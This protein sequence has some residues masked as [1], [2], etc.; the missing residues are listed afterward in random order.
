MA[1]ITDPTDLVLNTEIVVSTGAKT[2]Q[3]LVAGNLSNDGVNMQAVYSKLKELW[4]SESTL[5]PHPFPMV[6]IDADAGKYEIGTDGSNFNGWKWADTTTR[7][8]IRSA[9]W[10][11]ISDLGAL[12]AEHAGIRSL[13]GFEDAVND[14]AYYAVG[15][16]PTDIGAKIDFD[17]AGPVN[18]AILTYE[19]NVGPD[20]TTGFDFTTS[21]ISRN[22]AGS[23]VTD[24]YVVG[25]QVTVENADNPL[26]DLTAV[27]TAVTAADLTVA[28]TPFTV[29]TADQTATF[30]RNYRNALTLF[31]R[32]RDGDANGKTFAQAS[33]VDA[34][35]SALSNRLFSFPLG[36]ATDLNISET[37]ANVSTQSPYTEIVVRYFDQAYAR[38]GLS[39][40]PYNFGIVVDVGTHSLV[41]GSA[42]GAA[43]VLTSAEGG[44]DLSA[45]DGGT[46]YCHEGTDAGTSWPIVSTTATTITVTGTIASVTNGS[47]HAQRA[48]AVVADK[49]EIYEKVQYLLRQAADIDVTGDVVAGNTADALAEFVG[50]DLILGKGVPTNPNGGGSGVLVEGFDSNDTNNIYFYDNLA[51]S[52]NFPFVAAGSINFNANL[53]NDLGPAEY[54]MFFA[55]TKRTIPTDLVVNLAGTITSAGSELP[56]VGTGDYFTVSGLTGADEDM[57]GVYLASGTPTAA[58]IACTRYDGLAMEDTVAATANVDENPI[59]SPDALIVQNNAAADIKGNVPGASASFDFDYDGNTQGGRTPG[60]AEIVIR[61]IGYETAQFVETSGTITR[62]TGLSFSLVSALERNYSNP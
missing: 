54:W 38:D 4:K 19:K 10:R 11:E 44:I 59:D 31:L 32:V 30:A 47:F 27:V 60:D 45:Y 20:G 16:D 34:G 56:V 24:G 7:K 53:V 61:A 62:A 43:S 37:D 49:Y 46:L 57:N 6:A 39:G 50:P 28:G 9:G 1:V 21:V 26:N 3:L 25:G 15:N 18:E 22:D 35:E 58:S 8:L 55:Y 41:D 12:N 2:V 23:W 42:P 29:D 13:G 40:G 36:N 17:F 52:T 5:I 48:A 14:L 51:A 33:L